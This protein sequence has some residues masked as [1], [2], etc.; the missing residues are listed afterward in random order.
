MSVFGNMERDDLY[1]VIVSSTR[2]LRHT[3]GRYALIAVEGI[4]DTK[5]IKENSPKTFRI[6][7]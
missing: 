4:C 6:E 3:Y 7:I 2:T 5:T 1:V